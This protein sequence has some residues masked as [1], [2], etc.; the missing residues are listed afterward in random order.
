MAFKIYLNGQ[1]LTEGEI[2]L[3]TGVIIR[4]KNTSELLGKL[5]Q[6]H[7]KTAKNVLKTNSTKE[8]GFYAKVGEKYLRLLF[9][10]SKS[11]DEKRTN[12][13][14]DQRGIRTHDS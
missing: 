9:C 4:F 10:K 8:F 1:E 11:D 5:L 12:I 6:M 7:V 2:A 13:S 3:N 14:C